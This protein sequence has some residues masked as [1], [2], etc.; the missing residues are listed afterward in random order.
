VDLIQAHAPIC[1]LLDGFVAGRKEIAVCAR[2][3]SWREDDYRFPAV[4]QHVG[5]AVPSGKIGI[6]G[7]KLPAKIARVAP[8]DGHFESMNEGRIKSKP[9]EPAISRWPI[10]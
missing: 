1:V 10:F 9:R 7:T 2:I 6:A 5:K 8:A 3:F 4:A